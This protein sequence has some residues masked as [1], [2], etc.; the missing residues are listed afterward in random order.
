MVRKTRAERPKNTGIL[1]IK[2]HE[3]KLIL[4]SFYDLDPDWQNKTI[5]FI[6]LLFLENFINID[7]TQI[8]KW[9]YERM[10]KTGRSSRIT[11]IKA[12]KPVQD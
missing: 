10:R 4:E 9:G 2:T 11:V 7:K 8:Y 6:N 3:E 12:N 1:Q 5:D